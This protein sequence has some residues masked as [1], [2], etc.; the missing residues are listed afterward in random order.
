MVASYSSAPPSLW[1]P[2]ARTLAA[3][4]AGSAVMFTFAVLNGGSPLSTVNEPRSI[5]E[6]AG[7]PTITAPPHGGVDSLPGQ[8]T[9]WTPG[10]VPQSGSSLEDLS[11]SQAP[12]LERPAA[13]ASGDPADIVSAKAAGSGGSAAAMQAGE[14]P[15][16]R[17]VG[18]AGPTQTAESRY[19]SPLQGL[20]SGILQVTKGLAR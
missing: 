10:A 11:V 16:T 3:L 20:L 12:A 17:N 15:D 1:R 6:P 4:F 2:T 13:P 5:A 8:A 18:F 7:S 9:Q 14:D 19:G